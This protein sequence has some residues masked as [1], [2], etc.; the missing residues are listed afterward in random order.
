MVRK[1]ENMKDKFRVRFAFTGWEVQHSRIGL[2][3]KSIGGYEYRNKKDAESIVDDL[4]KGESC[5]DWF[6]LKKKE[7]QQVIQP[8]QSRLSK[9]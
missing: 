3:W 9:C 1:G 6:K 4:K 7:A 8:D 2:Y 5:A